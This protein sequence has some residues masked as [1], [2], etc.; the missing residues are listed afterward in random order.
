MSIA[1]LQRSSRTLIKNEPAGTH[2]P[3]LRL[4]TALGKLELL[5]LVLLV[6]LVLVLVLV[7]VLLFLLLLPLLLLLCF[8]F[9]Q[10]S[11][12]L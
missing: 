11:A 1:V 7:L 9:L 10:G 2:L 3:L 8:Q 4:D 5:L 6:L 12:C